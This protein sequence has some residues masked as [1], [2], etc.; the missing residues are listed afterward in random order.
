MQEAGRE[1]ANDGQNRNNWNSNNKRARSRNYQQS[2]NVRSCV[3]E[4]NRT[5]QSSAS[6]A[7]QYSANSFARIKIK[8]AFDNQS[9]SSAGESGVSQVKIR[10]KFH[11]R[12]NSVSSQMS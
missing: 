10:N 8:R 6:F 7:S 2:N 3:S 12:D 9:K 1:E 11:A 4:S 5:E